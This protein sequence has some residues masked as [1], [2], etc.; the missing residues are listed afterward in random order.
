MNYW[1]YHVRSLLKNRG[2][3]RFFACFTSALFR[4]PRVT[5]LGLRL[6]NYPFYDKKEDK[7]LGDR[8]LPWRLQ[9]TN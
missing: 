5:A 2:G 4:H 6:P 1:G 7:L 3:G 8:L 9:P